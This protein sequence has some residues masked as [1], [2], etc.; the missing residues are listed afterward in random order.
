MWKRKVTNRTF[1]RKGSSSAVVG[2][3]KRRSFHLLVGATLT[4]GTAIVGSVLTSSLTT[5]DKSWGIRLGWLAAG[6]AGTFFYLRW[7][8]RSQEG[9]PEAIK[10]RVTQL[11]PELRKQVQAR[12]YGARRQ[13]IEAPL[14]ELD[15]DITPRLG[16]VR[17]P[18]LIEPEPPS[19]K[20][21]D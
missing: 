15:L 19:E 8:L 5:G 17:D 9:S 2:D 1:P 16:W 12:S 11:G 10:E 6:I 4:I 14:R 3:N 20:V 13:L 7:Q 21:A 18:R